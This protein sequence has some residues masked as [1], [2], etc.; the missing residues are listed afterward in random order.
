MTCGLSCDHQLT[1]EPCTQTLQTGSQVDLR[2]HH[3]EVH[4]HWRSNMSVEDPSHM[5]INSVAEREKISAKERDAHRVQPDTESMNQ[6]DER[7]F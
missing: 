4:A 1:G 3:G 5:E 2:S 7:V 6:L